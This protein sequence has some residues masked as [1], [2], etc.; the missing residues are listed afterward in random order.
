MSIKREESWGNLFYDEKNHIFK[1][2]LKRDISE[3]PYVSKPIVLNVDLTFKCNMDCVHCVARD[4]A[5]ILGGVENSDLK[6]TDELIGKINV[7][8]FIAVVI[9]GGEPLLKDY[10]DKLISLINGLKNKGLIIDTNGSIF[11]SER[12]LKLFQRKNVLIRVSWDIPNPKK[13][14]K[15][16]K[17]P[18][19]MYENKDM[20]IN[21]KI[22]LIRYL[23]ANGIK[24]AIQSVL[25][26]QNCNDPTFYRS[27]P[28]KLKELGVDRWYIQRFIPSYK[29]VDDE[30]YF[31]SIDKYNKLTKRLIRESNKYNIKCCT[32]KDR[33]HNSVFL[34]VK[35]GKIYTQSDDKP[36]EKICLGEIG[37]IKHY[38]EFVSSSEHSVR[39]Y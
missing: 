22:N 31:I 13:E 16:R 9:T 34:L 28:E 23:I 24:I 26:G 6:I 18:Y 3:E 15:L 35:E 5:K 12:L 20:Y 29:R 4:T 10:E 37:E 25:H 17:Y 21:E 27:F 30:K 8:D 1:Y 39:Y 32:K 38:F 36:G 14:Y 19:K 7:S 11:P 2:D 33:R